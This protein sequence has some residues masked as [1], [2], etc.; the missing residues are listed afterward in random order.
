MIAALGETEE[1]HL[2]LSD[3]K[4]DS[5]SNYTNSLQQEFKPDQW[6]TATIKS[7][8]C[9]A[10]VLCT[11]GISDDLLP[12]KQMIFAQELYST[13]ADMESEKRKRDLKRWLNEWPVLGHTDDKTIACLFK[14]GD[15]Q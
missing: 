7:T 15:S 6:E 8:V 14:K 4:Q 9:N 13:Y 11:D 10:V 2:I 1:N 5:F 12:E 3:N